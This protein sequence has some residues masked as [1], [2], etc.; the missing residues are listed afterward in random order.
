MMKIHKSRKHQ[1]HSSL[2]GGR[3]SRRSN[4]HAKE[5]IASQLT[6][7][8]T[9]QFSYLNQNR[10]LLKIHLV[11]EPQSEGGFTVTC[12]VFPELITEGENKHEALIN[13]S[14]ALEAIID[15]FSFLGRPL[16]LNLQSL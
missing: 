2:R 8:M 6:L 3:S 14:D 16:P 10:D 5:A 7:A 9:G 15:A 11:L 13:A 12:P 1:I 4:L